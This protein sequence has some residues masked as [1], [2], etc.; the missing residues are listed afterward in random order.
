MKINYVYFLKKFKK[1][2]HLKK[3]FFIYKKLKKFSKTNLMAWIFSVLF[4]FL[5]SL[6]DKM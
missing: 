6:N 1:K 5:K 2:F 4:K 3:K